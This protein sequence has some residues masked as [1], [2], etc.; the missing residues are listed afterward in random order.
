ML[1]LAGFVSSKI[2]AKTLDMA[3]ASMKRI[4]G[5]WAVRK[6]LGLDEISFGVTNPQDKNPRFRH[7]EAGAVAAS[8]SWMVL[9]LP[10]WNIKAQLVRA[11]MHQRGMLGD[12]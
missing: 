6:I 4:V 2:Q 7:S 10:P 12:H 5:A 9:C 8:F 3:V 1:S 11:T